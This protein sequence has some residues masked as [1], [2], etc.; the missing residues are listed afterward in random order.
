MVERL[1]ETEKEHGI[2]G[3]N[4]AAMKQEMISLLLA[5]KPTLP[6]RPRLSPG[7]SPMLLRAPSLLYSLRLALNPTLP[8]HPNLPLALKPT[9]ALRHNLSLSRSRSPSLRS[10]LPPMSRVLNN[11]KGR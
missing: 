1:L 2:G 6:R 7:L 9:R 3:G 10:N 11:G 4:N 8:P 5:P